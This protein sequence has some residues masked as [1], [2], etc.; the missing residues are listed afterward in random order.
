M[1]DSEID[2]LKKLLEIY[3]PS[4]NEEKIIQFLNDSMKYLGFEVWIDSVG[5]V[6]GEIGSGKPVILFSS[7]IDTVPGEIEVKI[8]NGK[9]YGRGSI[10]AKGSCAAMILAISQ[11]VEQNF[12]GK[13]IFAGL[14][15]E[16]TSLR[17]VL[18]LIQNP[19]E[20]DY[21]IFG[22]P[23]GCDRIGITYKGRLS[24]KFLISSKMGQ[25]H[26]ANSWLYLN[27][28]EEGI[29]FWSQ[30]RD[31]FQQKYKGNSPFFSV[32]P[33]LTMIQAG[34]SPNVV[35]IT[36]LMN[37]DIR[38]PPGIDSN[39]IVEEINSIIERIKKD[40]EIEISYEILSQIEG[41]RANINSKIVDT[42]IRAIFEV[43]GIKPKMIRKTGTCFM[44]VI[45]KELQI[46]IISYGPGN[47]KIEHTINEYIEIQD[48]LDSIKIYKRIL[49][50]LLEIE[51]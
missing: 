19:I 37:I 41:Y 15:E 35:P 17:G 33:N 18:Q 22:E 12:K 16:E 48:Y 51:K 24:L 49:E 1:D 7:H 14:I 8:E 9:L 10:D 27:A 47:P 29:L 50:L 43:L 32:I 30:L 2:F 11:L 3:S 34:V 5:N 20:V 4:G 36:C 23:G 39:K 31:F 42:T 28:I 44:N 21:A 25:G 40:K 46:P 26:V 6:I 38:F 13:I 45:G